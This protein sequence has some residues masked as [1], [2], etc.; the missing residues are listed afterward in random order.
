MGITTTVRGKGGPRA[1]ITDPVI[2]CLAGTVRTLAKRVRALE[3]K[4]PRATGFVAVGCAAFRPVAVG[5]RTTEGGQLG[6]GG[7]YGNADEQNTAEE[8]GSG[9]A[10]ADDSKDM[11]TGMR[12]DLPYRVGKAAKRTATA[13]PA[14][15]VTALAHEPVEVTQVLKAEEGVD[16]A[17]NRA[18]NP[19]L[20]LQ[21]AATTRQA[22]GLVANELKEFLE[23][24]VADERKPSDNPSK[25]IGECF[26]KDTMQPALGGGL[27]ALD[28][29][30]TEVHRAGNQ[31]VGAADS[32][33]V[34]DADTEL[35]RVGHLRSTAEPLSKVEVQGLVNDFVKA[36]PSWAPPGISEEGIVDIIPLLSPA[37]LRAPW[38]RTVPTPTILQ[39][40]LQAAQHLLK[41]CLKHPGFF[42][43]CLPSGS[44]P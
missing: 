26:Q 27:E 37:I 1:D 32:K 39:Y 38:T 30:D 2:M 8:Q 36:F 10:I 25:G 22:P 29:A 5:C 18:A 19:V 17:I 4:E 43:L 11:E 42:R 41:Q 35:Y 3:V 21:S 16:K 31:A 20:P 6:R 44:T 9:Q 13:V 15:G 33:A 14:P 34:D 24:S 28:H 23:A 12:P 7:Q 40:T